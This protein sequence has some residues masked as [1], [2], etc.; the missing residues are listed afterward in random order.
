M[1]AKQEVIDFILECRI[2]ERTRFESEHHVWTGTIN[3]GPDLPII[4][5]P[6]SHPKKVQ[7][8]RVIFE[9][10]YRPLEAHE[11]VYRTQ[12]CNETL[13]VKPEHL[14]ALPTGRG[15]K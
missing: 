6:Y 11:R 4:G 15:R 2:K 14:V 10:F 1:A 12:N 7:V 3:C 9:K 13:C 8:R 5:V